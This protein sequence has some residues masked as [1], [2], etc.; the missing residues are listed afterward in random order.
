MK[1]EATL[2]DFTK[3]VE[4]M[5]Q[6]GLLPKEAYPGPR[7]G[8]KCQC[9]E[10]GSLVFPHY[11]TI[12][13]LVQKSIPGGC[14][15][16][17]KRRGE[18]SRRKAFL[19]SLP[20]KLRPF[21]LKLAGRYEKAKTETDFECL[22][23]GRSLRGTY[24]A[25]TS[26]SGSKKKCPCK[27]RPRKPLAIFEPELAEELV[28]DLNQG[29][30]K[31]TIGTG[32]RKKVWW[33]CRS[34]GHLFDAWP[35]ARCGKTRTGCRYCKGLE[36]YPGENDLESLHPA[37]CEELSESQEVDF[38]PKK[39]SEGSSKK[40]LWVCKTNSKHIYPMSPYERL[41]S[42]SG[43]SFCAGKRVLV[44][45]NDLA[46]LRPELALEWDYSANYPWRPE[47]FTE[48]SNQEFQ[49]ICESDPKHRWPAKIATR[50]KGHG[51]RYCARVK[52]G[53]NDLNSRAITHPGKKHLISEWSNLNTKDTSQVAFSCN[54]EYL[55]RCP[56]GHSDYESSP[57]NRW[58]C[59]TGCPTCAP[60]AYSAT[61]PGRLY[62]ISNPEL[63]AMK[64]GITNIDAKTD[65][66]R[67]FESK[68][69]QVIHTVEHENG[70]VARSIEKRMFRHVREN[71]G[72]PQFL[73]KGELRPLGGETET[74]EFSEGLLTLSGLIDYHFATL[75]RSLEVTRTPS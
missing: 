66:V 68:G 33:R 74:F 24:D 59:N 28:D 3:N 12:Q 17:G 49:W 11:S 73:E 55:W 26:S 53:R 56:E 44:G 63:R 31:D 41:A 40:V 22:I 70:A 37:L 14:K 54:D 43:C 61:K 7:Q 1:L 69:W 50:S 57:A 5:M 27:K 25:F 21:D 32:L 29:F 58:F 34:K 15:E 6:R 45:D 39:L 67:R 18:E 9:I 75:T 47:Q 60:S 35:S 51:C 46:T 19:D 20:E 8:W 16:C 42:G 2:R 10:C 30:T 23:C 48:H 38:D 13:Q 64:I 71:L 36:A 72:L 65:R 4:T 62:F 52:V